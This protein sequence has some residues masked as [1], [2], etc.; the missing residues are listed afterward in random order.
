M[1]TR[2]PSIY[3]TPALILQQLH[4]ANTGDNETTE[5]EYDV[6]W[7]IIQRYCRD[8]SVMIETQTNRAFVPYAATKNK[9]FAEEIRNGRFFY[10]N[11]RYVL[12]L[13]EDLLTVDSITWDGTTVDTDEYRLV[14]SNNSA[15]EYPYTRILFD[16]LSIPTLPVFTTAFS[17][18]IDIVGEWGVHDNSTAA[19]TDVTTL[20]A[21]MSDTTG[22]TIT[23]ADN[24]ALS[25]QIYQY[26]RI[27]DELMLIT[28]LENTDAPTN[29]TLTVERGVNGFTA[30]THLIS[31]TIERWNVV[32]DVEEL[33]T[34]M[35]AFYFGK[36]DD[37]G[38][39]INVLPD[40]SLL[41]AQFSK[42]IAAVAQRRR[43][44]LMGV[45]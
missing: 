8:Y 25:F 34:R 9:Y 1:Q 28:D 43:R 3:T 44:S 36:R 14:G 19:Y 29:D 35:C 23:L 33:G 17:T 30:A 22:T 38:E 16:G 24:G 40:G 37:T 21:A 27:D 42:E 11:G 6:D 5:N 10:D 4:K 45:S 2:P 15:D 39:M 12:D 13:W 18:S 31:T 20:A 7:D 32:R 26:I 41:L